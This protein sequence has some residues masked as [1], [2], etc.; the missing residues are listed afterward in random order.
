MEVHLV[1]EIKSLFSGGPGPV[2]KN[3]LIF[4]M[5]LIKKFGT[6]YVYF[7]GIHHEFVCSYAYQNII[8]KIF[9]V[10]QILGLEFQIFEV[11]WLFLKYRGA[12]SRR[13]YHVD[14][15]KTAVFHPYRI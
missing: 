6:F 13:C 7:N 4:L 3:H 14:P 5:D 11:G 2:S 9:N 12:G 15:P 8:F 10:G 1:M